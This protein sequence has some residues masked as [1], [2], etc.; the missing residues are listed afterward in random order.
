VCLALQWLDIDMLSGSPWQNPDGKIVGS[1]QAV[2]PVI[3]L[4]GVTSE[5]SSVMVSVHGFTPYFY[6][7]LPLSTDLNESFLGALRV[8]LDQRVCPPPPSLLPVSS[9]LQIRD[10]ARGDEKKLTSCVLAIEKVSNHQSLL[11]Y[12][13]D[14]TRDFIKVFMAMPSLVPAA[15]RAFD[16]GIVVQGYGAVGG[17]TYESNVLFILRYLFLPPSLSLDISSLSAGS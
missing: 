2:V 12:H 15:K 17:Q 9:L 13:A 4:Y 6:V 5:G 7:S 3:R 11:G 1:R 16:E 14:S 10:R 8:T